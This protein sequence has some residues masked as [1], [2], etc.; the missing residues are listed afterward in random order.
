MPDLDQ[1]RVATLS[2]GEDGFSLELDDG[3]TV[4][5]DKVILAVGIGYFPYTPPELSGLPAE[6]LSHSSQHA[7]L[8]GFAGR[9][10]AVVGAGASA[11]RSRRTAAPRRSRGR[12]D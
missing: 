4:A 5:A 9:H 2:R 12:R 10:V 11:P 8:E 7:A 3:T 6:L 1:R